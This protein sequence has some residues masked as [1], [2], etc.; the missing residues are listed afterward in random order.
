MIS[1]GDSG[2]SFR[3]DRSNIENN[4]GL[5]EFCLSGFGKAFAARPLESQHNS[6]G[7]PGN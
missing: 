3:V 6:I 2:L 7:L 1:L 5:A 4:V